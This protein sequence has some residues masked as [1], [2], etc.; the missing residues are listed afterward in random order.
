MPVKRSTSRAGGETNG[1]GRLR[2]AETMVGALKEGV[3]AFQWIR[4]GFIRAE[5]C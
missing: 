1:G 5:K 2:Q 3:E 4:G